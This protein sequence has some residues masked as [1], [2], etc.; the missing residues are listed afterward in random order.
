MNALTEHL[1]TLHRE[2]SAY[3]SF[4]ALAHEDDT[5]WRE[6]EAFKALTE[7]RALMRERIS[8]YGYGLRPQA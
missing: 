4:Y 7:K 6:Y 2:V 1:P 5:L 8:Q 3:L